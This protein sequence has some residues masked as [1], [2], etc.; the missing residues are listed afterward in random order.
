MGWRGQGTQSDPLIIDNI[1]GLRPHLVFKTKDMHIH[2]E[3]IKLDTIKLNMCENVKIKGCKIRSLTLEGC[4]NNVIQNNTIIN[5][6]SMF[7]GANDI[8]YNNISLKSLDNL[9]SGVIDNI[10][11]ILPKLAFM[12]SLIFIVTSISVLIRGNWVLSIFAVLIGLI[13]LG[14]SLN[15]RR[16]QKRT[17]NL[18]ANIIGN[19][20]TL[21]DTS[22]SIHEI[23]LFYKDYVPKI[24]TYVVPII[25]GV[26][27]GLIFGIL[28][29]LYI[30]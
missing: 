30:W 20:T 21:T 15:Y 6:N 4:Y 2:I 13:S 1:K 24:R 10:Y 9:I 18:P 12:L 29:I 25:I 7:S 3:R 11:Y 19:N 23:Y 22:E 8:V 5:F 28:S 14:F 17:E 26:A 27:I 16:K